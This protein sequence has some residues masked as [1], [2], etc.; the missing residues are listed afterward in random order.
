MAA[1][2]NVWMV[3]HSRQDI[4][5]YLSTLRICMEQHRDAL[6]SKRSERVLQLGR[7]KECS[8][9]KRQEVGKL[10]VPGKTNV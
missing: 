8:G 9:L 6:R 10:G 4:G 5:L 2:G 7:A 3:L 1:E